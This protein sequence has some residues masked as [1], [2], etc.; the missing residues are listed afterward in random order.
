MTTSPLAVDDNPASE[1]PDPT[2]I[3]QQLLRAATEP[4]LTRGF[5]AT[6]IRQ[7][8]ERAGVRRPSGI[9]KIMIGHDVADAVCNQATARIH[10]FRPRDVDDL[11]A[12]LVTWTE[13]AMARP[14]WVRLELELAAHGNDGD[15][16]AAQR[17]SQLRAAVVALLATVRSGTPAGTNAEEGRAM[18]E[19]RAMLVWSTLIGF[20]CRNAHN[21]DVSRAA[22]AEHIG[23]V[24]RFAVS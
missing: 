3:R 10:R 22:I 5:S 8:I 6:S 15:H 21:L 1:Q 12:M 17:S 11:I 2:E 20:V 24:V 14:G 13:V 4:F 9:S 18:D 23:Y 16:R 19:I 7:I